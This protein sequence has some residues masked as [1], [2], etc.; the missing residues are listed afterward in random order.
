M[1]LGISS[2]CFYPMETEKAVAAL[3]EKGVS[4]IEIFLNAPRELQKGFVSEMKSIVGSTIVTAIHPYTSGIEP[5]DLFSGYMR[6]FYD[7]VEF[8][9]RYA[10]FCLELG[11]KYIPFHGDSIVGSL[12]ENEYFERFDFLSS[13]LKKEGATLLQENVNLFRAGYTDFIEHMVR[14][15]PDAEFLFDIKQAVRAKQDPFKM[16]EILDGR[17][18]HVHI[19]DSNENHDCLL[20]F[21]GDFDL[22]GLIGKL[23]S[24]EGYMIIE[25]YNNCYTN[26]NQLIDSYEKMRKKI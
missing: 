26:I 23:N 2:S 19:S 8:Y 10:F 9:K 18:R 12:S 7:T 22:I 15:V 1:K 14:A 20:P 24:V 25:V 11:A 5:Y 21:D 17:I 6:R 4:S 16:L 13:T 3:V